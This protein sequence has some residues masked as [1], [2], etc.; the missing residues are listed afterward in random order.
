MISFIGTIKSDLATSNAVTTFS[1]KGTFR[2]SRTELWVVK[3]EK[4]KACNYRKVLSVQ[5]CRC[6]FVRMPNAIHLW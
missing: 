4:K 5:E 3:F 6:V 1:V 2:C